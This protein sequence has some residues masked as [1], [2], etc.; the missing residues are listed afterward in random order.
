LSTF[1]TVLYTSSGLIPSEILEGK[2]ALD[3]GTAGIFIDKASNVFKYRV[4]EG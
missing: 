3:I 2:L 4:S 1:T